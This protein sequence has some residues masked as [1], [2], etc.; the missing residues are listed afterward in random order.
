MTT[1]TFNKFKSTTIYGAFNNIDYLDNTVQASAFFQRA[2]TCSGDITCSG[3]IYGKNGT[4]TGYLRAPT[5]AS[6]ENSINVATTAYVKANL[7]NYVT[8]TALYQQTAPPYQ[9]TFQNWI[10]ISAVD[11]MNPRL[12]NISNVSGTLNMSTLSG[13]YPMQI[14]ASNLQ[15]STNN[16]TNYYD[17]LTTN[18]GV[19]LLTGATF[20]G[21]LNAV[22][23]ASTDNS[24]LVATTA[25]VKA[26]NYL[27]PI[28][29]GSGGAN[30]TGALYAQTP[31]TTENSRIV[32]TTAYVKAQGYVTSA[33]IGSGYAPLSGAT[34][35]GVINANA[36][37][38]TAL[39]TDV[40]IQG[41]QSFPTTNSGGKT[42]I[43]F[44]WNKTSGTGETDL[45]C[46][47][48]GG[49]GGL[50]IYSSNTTQTPVHIADFYPNISTFFTPLNTITPTT[51][52]NSTLVATTAYVKAQGYLTSATLGSN[53]GSLN[54]VN[55]W[56]D[57][58]TFNV[59]TNGL[60]TYGTGLSIG[61]NIVVG[62]YETSFIANNGNHGGGFRFYTTSTGT[63][64]IG[65]PL[66]SIYP[67]YSTF[68]TPLSAP[69]P[70]TSDNSTLVAT[71]AFVKAQNYLT[72]ASIVSI[73]IPIVPTSSY[74]YVIP[75]GRLET[76]TVSG[77]SLSRTSLNGVHTLNYS[78]GGDFTNHSYMTFNNIGQTPNG[79]YN[80][81]ASNY[82]LLGAGGVAPTV[83]VTQTV[84][85]YDAG[86]NI[87]PMYATLVD[88]YCI[89]STATS[90]TLSTTATY[91]VANFRIVYC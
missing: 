31:L 50:S 14:N 91:S 59:N 8:Y 85:V 7:T 30:F 62:Q 68:N 24:T 57:V 64:N 60:A 51:S 42:G 18:T 81:I 77:Y 45:L 35:T 86:G 74:L 79:S 41:N 33:S 71:T 63:I 20:T 43:G 40:N 29:L 58:N 88:G 13:L 90:A 26:Q 12:L 84:T 15:V 89:L 2:I 17:V 16:G 56:T 28:V 9:P 27:T 10:S 78:L 55:N 53:Y 44:F 19:A 25:Y 39:G 61:Q 36:G 73:T 37:L 21:A 47:G 6:S 11:V 67:T 87:I 69:T 1:P 52:D 72:S 32:A 75:T 34:F 76:S 49:Q 23:Q 5:T 82:I 4:F 66:C 38:S 83:P 54:G 65:T 80:L 3:I 70:A 22:T 48:Q 46:Y